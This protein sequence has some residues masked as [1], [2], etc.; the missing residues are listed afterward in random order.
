MKKYLILAAAGAA[1]LFYKLR[2]KANMINQLTFSFVSVNVKSNFDLLSVLKIQL[3][4]EV[5]NI[6]NQSL[7]INTLNADIS[8]NNI[9]LGQITDTNIVI[10]PNGNTKISVMI[11]TFTISLLQTVLNI[12]NS[13]QALFKIKGY[14]SVAAV[15]VPFEVEKNFL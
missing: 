10:A 13:K 15:S 9:N 1:Y 5:R 8:V 4:F 2:N 3:V 6:T 14:A 7:T 12:L 11:D